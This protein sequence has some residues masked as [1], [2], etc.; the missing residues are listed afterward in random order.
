MNKDILIQKQK[1]VSFVAKNLKFS[2]EYIPGLI[3][4]QDEYKAY[5]VDT[6]ICSYGKTKEMAKN[7]A[8]QFAIALFTQ[9]SSELKKAKKYIFHR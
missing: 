3:E 5:I 9:D 7:N 1:E 4:S 2:F 8:I 6:D